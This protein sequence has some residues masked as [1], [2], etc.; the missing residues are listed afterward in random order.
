[1]VGR[2]RAQ[3]EEPARSPDLM[4]LVVLALFLATFLV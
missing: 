2:K 4:G 3:K 1:M